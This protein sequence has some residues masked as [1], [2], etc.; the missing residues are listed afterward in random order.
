MHGK[1]VTFKINQEH[2][3]FCHRACLMVLPLCVSSQIPSEGT[4]E[5]YE[6]VRAAAFLSVRAGSWP[7]DLDS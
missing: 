3:L 2:F 5:Q 7:A 6:S 1:L 4:I